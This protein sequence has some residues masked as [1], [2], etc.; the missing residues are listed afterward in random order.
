MKGAGYEGPTLSVP[1]VWEMNMIPEILFFRRNPEYMRLYA[2][3]IM[4]QESL[5]A[6]AQRNKHGP[7]SKS[8]ICN[9]WDDAQLIFDSNE[10]NIAVEEVL[11]SMHNLRYLGF[12]NR[13]L[14]QNI[15][16]I[17]PAI[18]EACTDYFIGYVNTTGSLRLDEDAREKLEINRQNREQR[19]QRVFVPYLHVSQDNPKGSTFYPADPLCAGWG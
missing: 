7:D 11:N 19:G 3:N 5:Y 18:V 8:I 1:E 12:S 13:F 4:E 14:V 16:E 10:E 2:K 6:E 15:N 9:N 17:H